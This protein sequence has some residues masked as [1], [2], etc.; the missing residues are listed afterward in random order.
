M[1]YSNIISLSC[2]CAGIEHI[3]RV[4]EMELVDYRVSQSFMTVMI[5]TNLT[6]SILKRSKLLQDLCSSVIVVIIILLED[7]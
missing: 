2:V 6:Q 7:Y 5:W 3:V 1:I 4:L